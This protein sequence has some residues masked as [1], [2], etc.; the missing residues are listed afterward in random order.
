MDIISCR[1]VSKT[2]SRHTGQRLLR[3][4]M[5]SWLK[6][7]PTERFYAL[8]DV[9]FSVPQGG[10]LGIC[11]HNGAGKS[12]LLSLLTGLARPDAG[13]VSIN[14]RV[15]ALLELGSGFHPDLTGAENLRLNAALLGFSR[16]QVDALSEE[17]VDFAEIRDFINEPLRT[18][19]TGMVLRLGF[20]ISINLNPEILL[21]DEILAV[22]DQMFQAKCYDRIRQLRRNGTTFVCVSH[23]TKTLLEFCD[24][25]L[26][27]DHG[28]VVTHGSMREVIDEYQGRTIAT[29]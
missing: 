19:S 2:Y 5:S 28:Q 29:I 9:S 3:H 13:T 8:R 11:G 23:A 15:A 16:K 6:R 27:L 18:Y 22:G 25:G 17:I 4:H 26:L 12:T 10:S 21:V 20:S 1:N 14:G 7:Q 24:T